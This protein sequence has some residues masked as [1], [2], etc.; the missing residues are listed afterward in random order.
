MSGLILRSWVMGK[1]V[2]HDTR[3]DREGICAEVVFDDGRTVQIVVSSDGHISLR[4]WGN[5]PAKLGNANALSLY[6]SLPR[7]EQTHDPVT[8]LP[9]RAPEPGGAN[10]LSEEEGNGGR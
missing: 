10:L 1:P 6:C 4:G 2:V 5:V 9:L 3:P 8:Y 7:E